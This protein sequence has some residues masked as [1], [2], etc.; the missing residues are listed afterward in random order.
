MKP[1]SFLKSHNGNYTLIFSKSCNLGVLNDDGDIQWIT[2]VDG[3]DNNCFVSVQN[4]GNV[5]IY[6]DNDHEALWSSESYMEG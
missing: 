3:R 1:N 6:S 5:V 2:N 4:D